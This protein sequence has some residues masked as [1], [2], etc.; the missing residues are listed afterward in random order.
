[1][2]DVYRA[3]GIEIAEWV[4]GQGGQMDDGV[5]P[6]QVFDVEV[7]NVKPKVGNR[8]CVIA[9]DAVVEKKAVDAADVWPASRNSGTRQVPMYPR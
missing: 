5:V 7:P 8:R 2:V 4:I 6:L 1:M 9:E 3:V